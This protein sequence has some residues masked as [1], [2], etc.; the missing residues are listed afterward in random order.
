MDQYLV[1]LLYVTFNPWNKPWLE[2]EVEE[3]TQVLI[4]ARDI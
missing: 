1:K 2:C 4:H 3:L